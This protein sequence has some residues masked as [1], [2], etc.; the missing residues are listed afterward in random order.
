[1]PVKTAI[2]RAA[3][4]MREDAKL[5]LIALSSLTIA[6]LCLSTALFAIAN[7]SSVAEAWGGSARMSVYLVD[8]AQ[9]QDVQQLRLLLDGLSEVTSVEYLSAA[10]AQRRFAED[11]ELDPALASLPVE[12]FPASLEIDLASHTASDRI[13]AIGARLS[14]FDAVDDVETYVGWFDRLDSLVTTG[15]IAAGV[16]AGLVLLC[17]LF[18]VANTI[19]LAIAGRRQEI[20]V[21]KLCGAS[22]GFVRG[23]FLV[24]GAVQGLV[25][26][27]LA[28]LLLL[29]AFLIFREEVDATIAALAGVRTVFL[30]LP[31]VVALTLGGAAIGAAGS[32]MSLRRYLA[33]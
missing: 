29:V 15:R 31:V 14:A 8:G 3:R 6:F 30:S 20:E 17:V 28:V 25:S 11:S 19:R 21:L 10:E 32:A 18:V 4:A 5:H 13:A 22:D 24:E 16:L 2:A 33:V 27:A 23:P 26:S 12:A 9:A 1:M 7:L